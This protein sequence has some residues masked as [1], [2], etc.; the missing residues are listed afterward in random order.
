M[1]V[2]RMHQPLYN[3]HNNT[4]AMRN[5]YMMRSALC[6]DLEAAKTNTLRYIIY[7]ILAYF[8]FF[9]LQ[10]YTTLFIYITL[11]VQSELID[12]LK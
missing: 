8:N 5:F 7:T 2:I 10:L 12:L 1:Y 11:Y 4:Q 9:P 6:H 3:L